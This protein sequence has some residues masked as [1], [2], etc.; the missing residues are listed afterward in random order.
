MRFFFFLSFSLLALLSSISGTLGTDIPPGSNVTYRKAL[1]V[2]L[3][4]LH[5]SRVLVEESEL[6]QWWFQFQG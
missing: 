2:F 6:F 1:N 5:S 4:L 3:G